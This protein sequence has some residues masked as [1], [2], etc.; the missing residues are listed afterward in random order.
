MKPRVAIVAPGT[1]GSAIGRRLDEHG[2]QVLT[3][4]TGR[5]AA[6]IERARASGMHH[7]TDPELSH[8]DLFLSIVPPGQAE[9]VA[10]QYAALF[11]DAGRCPVYVDCNAVSPR[12]VAR[13]AAHIQGSG[14]AF[15]D[16]GI[17]GG[18]PKPG[19]PGPMLYCSGPSAGAAEALGRAGLRV[20]V[21]PGEIGAASALKMS[22]AGI[23][24]GLTALAATMM[25]A[26]SRNGAAAALHAE[27]AESQPHLL[28]QFRRAV[29]DMFGK[30][31][32]WVA[33]MHEIADFLE[34]DVAGG[35]VYRQFG[36]I[37]EALAAAQRVQGQTREHAEQ[38]QQGD[39]I[40]LLRAFFDHD[41]PL[42]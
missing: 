30:A 33:E 32:R 12:T 7:R 37:Y 8:A 24:K 31:Y 25:L 17:I 14:A 4:L 28:A 5:S 18:P 40:A 6:S 42:A 13:I 35:Q 3:S 26:A 9:A 38:T 1:M 22:Y 29:P 16:G 39:P 20:R 2:L 10:Q 15:V 21:L 23:T 34:A 19:Q 27:L 36:D 11:R 41:P